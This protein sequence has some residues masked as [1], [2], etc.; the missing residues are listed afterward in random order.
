M[1]KANVIVGLMLLL[2][3]SF[4]ACNEDDLPIKMYEEKV[5]VANRGGGSISFI[6][7][8][9]NQVTNTLP[10]AGS[11]PMYVVYVP[12]KDKIYVGDR[13]SNK[14]HIVNPE[15][16][17]VES[18]ITVGNGVFHMWA[19][20]QGKQLWVNNDVD[21]T[22]SVIDLNTNTVVKTINV[23]MKPHDVFLTNDATKAYVSVFNSDATMPDKIFMY[24]TSSYIK[25]AEASVGKDPHLFHLSNSNKLFVPCQSGQVYSLNGND[26]STPS[27]NPF[28]GAHGIFS[29]PDQ[30]NLFVTNITGGQIYSIDAATNTQN[31]TALA[32]L[33]SI[34]HN[35]VVNESGNKMFVT[36]SGA[37]ATTVSTY[38][39]NAATLTAGTT[40]TAGMNPFGL[41]YYKREIQ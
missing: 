40:I 31:G 9:S 16:Q 35:I 21:N 1:K 23:G 4:V 22:I 38:T 6:D 32:S 12:T 13:A 36:H 27:N 24:A 11:E 5:V 26:L 39:I 14:V 29:S 28:V 18:A 33:S 41:A 34:P 15:T 37:T 25:T 30:K 7:A 20:G 8:T 19:D 10:I 17:V 3:T 2:V